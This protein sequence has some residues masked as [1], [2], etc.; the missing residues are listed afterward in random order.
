MQYLKSFDN[1]CAKILFSDSLKICHF[2]S[3]GGV[4]LH[5]TLGFTKIELTQP[6]KSLFIT[7]YFYNNSRKPKN[8]FY[9]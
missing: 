8:S 1:K 4:T 5:Y 6:L 2:D 9:D 3:R 7:C